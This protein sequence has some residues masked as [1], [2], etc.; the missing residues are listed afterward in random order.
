MR[1]KLLLAVLPLLGATAAG[2]AGQAPRTR[3]EIVAGPRDVREVFLALP[4]PAPRP[5]ADPLAGVRA[6][7]GTFEQRNAEVERA[8]RGPSEAVVDTRN[9]YLRLFFP[10]DVDEA[11]GVDLVLTYFVQGNGDRLVVLH[12]EDFD[13]SAGSTRGDWF[14][15]L[16]GGR[17]TPRQARDVL[18]AVT[19]ADF[20]GDHPLPRG[21]GPRFFLD[22]G[23]YSIEWPREGTTATFHVFT[24]ALPEDREEELR[25][26]F[27]ARKFTEMELVWDRRSGR[28]TKGAKVPYSGEEEC[29]VD[30]ELE[31]VAP[32]DARVVR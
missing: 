23:A 16:S 25:E 17:F 26:L 8:L 18:P 29:E 5:G 30:H 24:S 31:I 10:S 22:L 15:T 9:G 13:E 2:A 6:R 14:W 32:P 1:N 27:T 7:L 4:L 3:A 19:Y 28:F 12:A 11:Y 21:I 20:W